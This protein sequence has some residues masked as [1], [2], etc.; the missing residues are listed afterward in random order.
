MALSNSRITAQEG[1]KR[2]DA[3]YLGERGVCYGKLIC[4][5]W[6]RAGSAKLQNRGRRIDVCPLGVG[7][8][9]HHHHRSEQQ[10]RVHTGND[11]KWNANWVISLATTTPMPERP[12]FSLSFNRNRRHTELAWVH[13]KINDESS[14]GKGF[15]RSIRIDLGMMMAMTLTWVGGYIGKGLPRGI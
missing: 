10:Q 13:N 5:Q 1:T 11:D 9:V 2:D 8:R 14:P 3:R 15:I 6:Y 7:W 4:W 12:L